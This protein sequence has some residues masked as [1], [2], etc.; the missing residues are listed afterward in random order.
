MEV[1][2]V[3]EGQIDARTLETARS[4]QAGE[5]AAH[6]DDAVAAE[7]PGLRQPACVHAFL[8][9]P[10][11]MLPA[12]DDDLRARLCRRDRGCAAAARGQA[13]RRAELV[14]RRGRPLADLGPV[15]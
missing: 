2:L 8:L 7:R 14:Q 6:D 11:S 1:P 10:K 3:E 5:S 15:H 4:V 13:A 12:R 9:A